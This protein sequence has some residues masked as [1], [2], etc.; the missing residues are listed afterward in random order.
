MDWPLLASL[1]VYVI[2]AVGIVLAI[3]Q[4]IADIRKFIAER[5]NTTVSPE[6]IIRGHRERVA[7]A[8]LGGLIL[9][10]WLFGFHAAFVAFPLLYVRAHGGTWRMAGLLSALAISVLVIVFD[11]LVHVLWPEPAILE[12]LGI[13][14]WS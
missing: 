2:A 1:G 11:T 5:H 9:C 14:L 12:W 6:F 4:F 13:E 10:V 3:P 8:W 7:W